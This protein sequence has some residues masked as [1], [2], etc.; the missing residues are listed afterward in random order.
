MVVN[1]ALFVII[2][3]CCKVHFLIFVLEITEVRGSVSSLICRG[4]KG[5][6]EV[7]LFSL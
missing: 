4:R 7:K 6:R 1:L 3:R 2:S 5:S